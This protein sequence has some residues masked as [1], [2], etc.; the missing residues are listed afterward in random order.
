MLPQ[1]FRTSINPLLPVRQNLPRTPPS[2]DRA[3]AR[4]VWPAS[5]NALTTS[6]PTVPVAPVTRIN[7]FDML[8]HGLDL[9][10]GR[11][12]GRG[13]RVVGIGGLYQPCQ[14]GHAAINLDSC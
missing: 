14:A 12:S 5:A 6:P 4:A 2:R 13:H 10:A 11:G 3:A 1:G 9:A 8:S 7:G